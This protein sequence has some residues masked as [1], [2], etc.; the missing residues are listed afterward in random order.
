[1][2]NVYCQEKYLVLKNIDIRNSA[3]PLMPPDVRC[4]VACLVYDSSHTRSFEYVAKVY[5]VSSMK[6]EEGIPIFIRDNSY[7]CLTEIFQW[8]WNSGVDSCK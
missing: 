3:E 7:H 2:V 4:D 1:M 5:L 6:P 8:Q